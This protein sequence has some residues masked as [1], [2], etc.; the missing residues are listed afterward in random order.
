M[1]LSFVNIIE[2]R[3]VFY[4]YN[5]NPTLIP[6]IAEYLDLPPNK[7][8]IFSF[9]RFVEFDKDIHGTAI[10][11]LFDKITNGLDRIV[12]SEDENN[13]QVLYKFNKRG[14]VIEKLTQDQILFLCAICHHLNFK[15]YL[16]ALMDILMNDFKLKVDLIKKYSKDDL[17]TMQ[18]FVD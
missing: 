3:A 1:N 13:Y 6:L 10:T 17:F 4:R 2:D 16:T 14:D 5:I 18:I 15:S 12:V 8:F 7:Q 11:Y 9:G